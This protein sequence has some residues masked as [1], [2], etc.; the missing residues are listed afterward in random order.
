MNLYNLHIFPIVDKDCFSPN[1]IG[2]KPERAPKA[3]TFV[4]QYMLIKL[5][6]ARRSGSFGLFKLKIW[7]LHTK[8]LPKYFP[9]LLYCHVRFLHHAILLCRDNMHHAM[10]LISFVIVVMA[11]WLVRAM[12]D[13]N[14]RMLILISYMPSVQ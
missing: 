9:A 3:I 14:A 4:F 7:T 11:W 2:H 5:S 1:I 13:Q 6:F 10:L 12:C 8:N